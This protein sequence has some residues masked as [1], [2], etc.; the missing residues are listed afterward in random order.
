MT[1]CE[2]KKYLKRSTDPWI[3]RYFF[4]RY[5]KLLEIFARLQWRQQCSSKYFLIYVRSR[6][7]LEMLF[8]PEYER[9]FFSSPLICHSISGRYSKR[10][11]SHG[12]LC[13]CYFIFGYVGM[14]FK[15]IASK[16]W[17]KVEMERIWRDLHPQV[18]RNKLKKEKCILINCDA[19]RNIY[20]SFH[21]GNF[22]QQL[23]NYISVAHTR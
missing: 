15:K 19:A 23:S 18:D 20:G 9:H 22:V 6:F 10:T 4:F 2:P 21:R 8:L 13:H 14:R 7:T 1:Q 17:K 12:S 11:P 3:W 16:N 5:S